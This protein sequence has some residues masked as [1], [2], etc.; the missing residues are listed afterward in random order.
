MSS[1][2]VSEGTTR[3]AAPVQLPDWSSW[4][5]K[6]GPKKAQSLREY[7]LHLAAHEWSLSAA[8]DINSIEDFKS[9]PSPRV[10]P[11][12]H[13]V[14]DAILFFRRLSPRGL[15]A[16]DVGLG[17]TIT[18]GLIAR[19]LLT[20][21]RIESFL[22]VSPKSLNEQWREELETKFGIKARVA[23]GTTFADLDSNRFWITSYDTARNRMEA[24]Q[25]RKFDLLILDEAHTLRNLYGTQKSPQ[26]AVAFRDLMHADAVRFCLMLT[27]TPIQNRLWDIYSL[28]EVLKA[29][30]PNPLGTETS[31]QYRFIADR[32]A[33][34]LTAG[35]QEAFRRNIGE[36]TVRTRRAD[37]Q[38][39]FPSREVKD[40]RLEP[41]PEEAAFI[42]KA[43]TALLAFNPLT[44]ITLARSLM[45]SPWAL[46]ASFEKKAGELG[47]RH[48]MSAGLQTLA[49]TGRAIKTSAKIEAVTELAREAMK[50]TPRRRLVVFTQRLE[51]LRHLMSVLSAHGLGDL[52][53]TIQGGSHEANLRSIAD[54]RADPPRRPILLS[55]DT[56]AVGLNLQAGNI[57]V[58][59]DL[60]WNPMTL[61]Q[62]IGRVQRLGQK[63]RS[64]VIYNLVL[65][66]TMEDHI[67]LRLMEKL[68]LFSQAIGE[69]E[70]L[71]ELCGFTADEAEDRAA[72]QG[73]RA[74]SLDKVIMDL[75]RTAAL[76]GD[77]EEELRR[78]EASR[79]RAE[80]KLEE[81]RRA[82]EENLASI[83]PAD[84]GPKLEKLE[85]VEPRVGLK[86]LVRHALKAS[87]ADH[88]VEDDGR[89]LAKDREGSWFEL[90][91]DSESDAL[92]SP[93]ARLVAP[94]TRAF[95]TMMKPL[96]EN[97]AQLVRDFSGYGLDRLEEELRRRL[98]ER[99]MVLDRA[100]VLESMPK[101]ALRLAARLTASVANDRYETLQEFEVAEDAHDVRGFLAPGTNN[102]GA[103]TGA[104]KERTLSP[105][106]LSGS[107]AQVE[108]AITQAGRQHASVKRFTE[109]YRDR[110]EEEIE[111]LAVAAKTRQGGLKGS[112]V[113]V[114][115]VASRTDQG[116]AAAWK[117]LRFR[118]TPAL[119]ADPVGIVGL[120]YEVAKVRAH[121]RNRQQ[122]SSVAIEIEGIPLTGRVL[123][124]PFPLPEREPGVEA[125]GCPGGHLT[126]AEAF[127]RCSVAGCPNG[128]CVDCVTQASASVG[129]GH[130]G[131]C[132]QVVCQRHS[133]PCA[134]CG[135]V[136]CNHHEDIYSYL[137]EPVCSGCRTILPDG[138]VCRTAQTI[139]SSV[140]GQLI[141][142]AEA[143]ASERSGQLAA[144]S[145]M[146]I[147][148]ASGARLLPSETVVCAVTGKRVWKELTEE[149]AVSG[150]R[151]LRDVVIRS[152]VS[153]RPALPDE[154]KLCDETGAL[155]LPD[156][157][158]TCSV[159]K[160]LVRHDLLEEEATLGRPVLRR[161][162]Q[163]SDVSQRWALP[164]HLVKSTKTSR[165][166]LPEES[167]HCG[168]CDGDVLSDEAWVCPETGQSACAEHFVRSEQTGRAVLPEALGICEKTGKRVEH[169]L[170]AICAES[171]K[172]VQAELL[173]DCEESGRKV[174]PE[175][176]EVSAV[177]AKRVCRS[178]LVACNVTGERALPA[179]LEQCAVSGKH[180]I[181][182]LLVTCPESGKRLLETE[183]V[184]SGVTGALL[185]PEA[186]GTCEETGVRAEHRLLGICAESGKRVLAK[187]LVKCAE[188]GERVLPAFAGVSAVS[189]KRV[190]A[191][192]LGTCDVTG[193]RALPA[194]LER[195]SVT[196]KMVLPRLMVTCAETG[197]RLLESCAR[198]SSL[199]GV[200]LSPDAVGRCAV[201]GSAVERS[202]LSRDEVSGQTVLSRLLERCAISGRLTVA[203][204]LETCSISGKRVV[205][206]LLGQCEETGRK[207]LPA[208]L[209]RCALTGRQVHP[210]QLVTCAETGRTV[211]RREAEV[212]AETEEY[213]ARD[214]MGTCAR[215]AK[216]VRQSLLGKDEL[217]GET[218]LARLLGQCEISK[219]RTTEANLGR[220]NVSGWI[221]Q[222]AMLVACEETGAKAL[223]EELIRCDTTGK[224]VLPSLLGDCEF[225]GRRVL[226]RL[227]ETSPLSGRRF[228]VDRA[229]HCSLCG[230][231]VDVSEG[232]RCP[233]CQVDCC[234]ADEF[235]GRC[236]SCRM[237]LSTGR[238]VPLTPE[239]VRVLSSRVPWAKSGT[240]ADSTEVIHVRAVGPVL[241][242]RRRQALVVCGRSRAG[243][244][245]PVGEVIRLVP[246]DSK[247]GLGSS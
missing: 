202:L 198:R 77:V 147:C 148:E 243:S 132:G 128:A 156:E 11:F 106:S 189:G 121:V 110:Y 61:E 127:Q 227:L 68:A 229:H 168:V 204:H 197:K 72:G 218:V 84:D 196:G 57:V 36:A 80:A 208:L 162:L 22:I 27:A 99:G 146:V 123:S 223:P 21:G 224:A 58:N 143:V 85:R 32:E 95:D 37:T 100:E 173:T 5:S 240:R 93:G 244:L 158:E 213:V 234:R 190:R 225:S 78:A 108:G 88:R 217:T 175:F 86:E 71:L 18:A 226:R 167:A 172:R 12:E 222:H 45:S 151:A 109:Y 135:T 54:Y 164:E 9:L 176:T 43:L 63:A 111:K 160:R 82:T 53:G 211:L 13:Q 152:G 116:I 231:V 6:I 221:V 140:T 2:R 70:E 47:P 201:T 31:F 66:G 130:C 150:R 131:A 67:V 79:R 33:R 87:G 165:R 83:R 182:R 136:L 122:R 209:G 105:E 35:S 184:V 247:G 50:A 181:P 169:R 194:E 26:V 124:N 219:I 81:M 115:E 210:D 179:E 10:K 154:G 178:M 34:R 133:S 195:C 185:T 102:D 166:G 153:N 241:A 145:E 3:E 212:C 163:Q 120:R 155:L 16:D 114:L 48:P 107:F 119:R 200:A 216:R 193:E 8:L 30:Q 203:A 220:S 134:D 76:Q 98:E 1:E 161:L 180:V 207:A 174:L 236:R 41:L 205:P 91:T 239:D 186:V 117:S 19:E 44:Q 125:W 235:A 101:H 55:T 20:R 139:E 242:F 24:I 65:K 59:Y 14:Q 199:T 52:V 29:P 96:R 183:A 51:T 144:P 25:Q 7:E 214:R 23:T 171:G 141:P 142:V 38:L 188:T 49:A 138:R 97:S 215:T 187:K 15:I 233:T 159:T 245:S 103:R 94:G 92:E 170:L 237:A 238:G 73:G 118:Y 113:S 90:V 228:A 69:M 75:I 42:E 39:L 40:E 74:R 192:L 157:Y 89:I 230:I 232:F 28:L 104:G 177:S 62:R 149:S 46:A 112:T 126:Y 17:K 206:A 191:S 129:I 137:G 4:L 56:G 64:V 60:P 246:L